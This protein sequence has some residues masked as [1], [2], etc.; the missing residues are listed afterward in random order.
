[1]DL[2]GVE[3]ERGA[4]QRV[5]DDAAAPH[6]A[7]A[8]VVAVGRRAVGHELG[9]GV[10]RA[11]A[12]G[13]AQVAGRGLQHA[14]AEVG[15][16]DG[17]RLG[18]LA[19]EHQ[20]LQLEVAVADAQLVAEVDPVHQPAEER[21]RQVVRQPARR[22]DELE[23]VAAGAVPGLVSRGRGRAMWLGFGFG[24]GLGFGFGFE[25]GGSTP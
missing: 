6:V 8:R 16:L 19:G 25:V 21:A 5:E 18:L 2:V 13:A 4:E 20:V 17:G 24:F 23:Q 9:R 1:M 22:V 10:E 14:Q 7:P 15:D 11:A 12:E 3:G